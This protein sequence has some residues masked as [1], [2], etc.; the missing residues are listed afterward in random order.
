MTEENNRFDDDDL[1]DAIMEHLNE[2]ALSADTDAL[3]VW[4]RRV[5][6]TAALY[7]ATEEQVR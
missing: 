3:R 1:T 6:Q 2:F 4:A 7:F 5:I